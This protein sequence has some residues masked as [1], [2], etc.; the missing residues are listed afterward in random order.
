M[1]LDTTG[2]MVIKTFSDGPAKNAGLRTG[3]VITALDGRPVTGMGDLITSLASL[4]PGDEITLTVLRP[5]SEEVE[6]DIVLGTRPTTT[7]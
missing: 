4:R 5:G 6:I 2:A 7:Q 3:D 1:P